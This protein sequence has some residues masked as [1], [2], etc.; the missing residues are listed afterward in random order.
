MVISVGNM[1]VAPG[2]FLQIFLVIVLCGKEV[3]DLFQF[4]S[5]G[6]PCLFLLRIVDRTYLLQ[7]LTVRMLGS[8]A[9][10][11]SPVIPLSADR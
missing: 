4:H 2:I 11:D 6:A 9:I 5:K 1:A 10:L 8:C 3:P 7:L